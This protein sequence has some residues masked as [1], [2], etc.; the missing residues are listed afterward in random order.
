VVAEPQSV[1]RHDR[2]RWSR[3]ALT[4]E[5]V[6]DDVGGM[7]ALGQR[8]EARRVDCGQAVRKNRGEDFH[9]LPVAVVGP[10]ML[11]AA[12]GPTLSAAPNP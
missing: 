2:R 7:D 9:H 8:L 4:R 6:D 12:R 5:D 3:I 11:C 10:G 1:G